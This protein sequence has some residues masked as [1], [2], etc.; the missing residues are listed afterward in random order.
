M[1]VINVNYIYIYYEDEIIDVVLEFNNIPNVGDKI[2]IKSVL[3][4]VSDRE[5]LSDRVVLK[6]KKAGE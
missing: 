6:V 1:K 5:W 3:Y 4:I 2:R